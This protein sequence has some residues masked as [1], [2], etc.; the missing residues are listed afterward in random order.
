MGVTVV[1]VAGWMAAPSAAAILA[2]MGADVI[3]VEPTT[4][5]Y[6]RGAMRPPRVAEDDPRHGMDA[7]FQSDN[8]GKRSVAVNMK[9]QR[10]AD[11]VRRMAAEADVFICN[12]LPDRQRRF[13]ID[14]EQLSKLN[15]TIVHATLIGYGSH[16]EEADRPGYD[17]TAFWGR[18]GLAFLA[19]DP[20][21]GQPR[22][23][24]SA[25]GDHMTG[26]ALLSGILAALRAAEHTGRHQV[27]EASLLGT[28]LWAGSTDL[29]TTI[30]DRYQPSRRSRSKQLSPLGSCYPCLDD[31]WIIVTMPGTYPTAWQDLCEAFELSEL[32][33][34]PRFESG[35]DRFRNMGELLEIMDAKTRSRSVAQWGE[36]LDKAGIPWAPVQ[37][38]V[39]VVDDPQVRANGFITEVPPVE[40]TGGPIVE[41][42]AAPFKIAGSRI[43]P[44]GP[45]PVVGSATA[46]VLSQLGVS[47]AELDE[48]EADGVVRRSSASA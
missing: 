47:T 25:V 5:D 43:A 12:L 17:V 36:R 18:S 21:S 41:A 6:M 34:D 45:A 8:R 31:Q 42:V 48:L 40:L 16:G 7:A 27:V 29:S 38:P 4:G 26:L 11:L 1:E 30:L 24:P 10:G 46:A 9:D 22:T 37:S 3:K 32:A 39:D 2:D 44:Q 19:A 13:G 20:E 23:M 35:R 28:A 33:G 15:P 14:A